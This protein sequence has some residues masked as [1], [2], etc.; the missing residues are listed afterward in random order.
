MRGRCSIWQCALQNSTSDIAWHHVPDG[1][2]SLLPGYV[3]MVHYPEHSLL[4]CPILLS[5][6]VDLDTME[7]YLLKTAKTYLFEGSRHN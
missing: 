4:G 3:P 7:E 6:C 5:W 1:S 2:L